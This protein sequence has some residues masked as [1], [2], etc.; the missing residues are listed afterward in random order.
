MIT[1]LRTIF[2]NKF[3]S[4]QATKGVRTFRPSDAIFSSKKDGSGP[5]NPHKLVTAHP[6]GSLYLTKISDFDTVVSDL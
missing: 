5:L 2:Q 6:S 4:T 3:I 1:E